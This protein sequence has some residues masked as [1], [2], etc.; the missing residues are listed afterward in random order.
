MPQRNSCW[1]HVATHWTCPLLKMPQRH[2]HALRSGHIAL[3]F[4]ASAIPCNPQGLSPKGVRLLLGPQVGSIGGTSLPPFEIHSTPG[5]ICVQ[6]ALRQKGYT[7]NATNYFFNPP[8]VRAPPV[9]FWRAQLQFAGLRCVHLI[10]NSRWHCL[11]PTGR[12]FP[13]FPVLCTQTCPQQAYA[14]FL[15][16]HATPTRATGGHTNKR[17]HTHSSCMRRP[18]ATAVNDPVAMKLRCNTTWDTAANRHGRQPMH[19]TH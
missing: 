16:P 3:A 10:I 18:A 15:P 19:H 2:W 8:L 13:V 14:P 12:S 7:A 17:P 6:P 4:T 1:G 9:C 11:D 5:T